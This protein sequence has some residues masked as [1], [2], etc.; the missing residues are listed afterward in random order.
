MR[1]C[2]A[3]DLIDVICCKTPERLTGPGAGS[4]SEDHQEVQVGHVKNHWNESRE[5]TR[6]DQFLVRLQQDD[7]LTETT[8]K[9]ADCADTWETMHKYG[10]SLPVWTYNNSLKLVGSR[11]ILIKKQ[12][13][14]FS[15]FK[16]FKQTRNI[17]IKCRW[18]CKTT[19]VSRRWYF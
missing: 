10:S 7:Q 14:N 19:S 6:K 8:G 18:S 9:S 3:Q 16:M 17:F 1:S 4:Q 13:G 5:E 15:I 11:F 2:H 12:Y